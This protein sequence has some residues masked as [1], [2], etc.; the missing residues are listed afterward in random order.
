MPTWRGGRARAST[1][2]ARS[3][4]LLAHLMPAPAGL[5]CRWK[6][7]A[8][9]RYNTRPH[10]LSRPTT[11]DLPP[12]RLRSHTFLVRHSYHSPALIRLDILQPSV[13]W[14]YCIQPG[15]PSSSARTE[16]VPLSA[17]PSPSRAFATPPPL[18]AHARVSP[19]AIGSTATRQ[20]TSRTHRGV[21]QIACQSFSLCFII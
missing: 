17:F 21:L 6:G 3:V 2:L 4:L 9:L 20:F 15:R 13:L 18:H 12:S 19:H 7:R 14:W 8:R 10:P 11:H 16:V 5:G 1:L